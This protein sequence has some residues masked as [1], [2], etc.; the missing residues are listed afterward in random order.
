M[1]YTIEESE[2]SEESYTIGSVVVTI[3][4]SE[5]LWGNRIDGITAILDS[6][7]NMGADRVMLANSQAMK[8]WTFDVIAWVTHPEAVVNYIYDRVGFDQIF[9]QTMAQA[10]RVVKNLQ[11]MDIYWALHGDYAHD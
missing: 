3:A 6:V 4:W 7:F 2:E 11:Q 5:P 10:E 9:C 1:K 8:N